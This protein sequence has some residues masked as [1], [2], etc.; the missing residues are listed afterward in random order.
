MVLEDEEGV[1]THLREILT[2]SDTEKG[3]ECAWYG[4]TTRGS[5]FAHPVV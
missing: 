4:R 1:G 5:L 2:S 3:N